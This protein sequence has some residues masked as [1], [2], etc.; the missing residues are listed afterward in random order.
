MAK[1]LVEPQK[2]PASE[3]REDYHVAKHLG[4]GF[5]KRER[6][7]K[8]RTAQEKR[9]TKAAK[10]VQAKK[11][12]RNEYPSKK[13]FNLAMEGWKDAM[14]A[15]VKYAAAESRGTTSLKSGGKAE[16]EQEKKEERRLARSAARKA[17]SAARR[18]REENMTPDERW[19]ARKASRKKAKEMQEAL[20]TTGIG[21]DSS[22][23]I[24][25]IKK[26]KNLM[27][28]QTGKVKKKSSDKIETQKSWQAYPGETWKE[29]NKRRREERTAARLG[30]KRERLSKRAG[31]RG[32]GDEIRPEWQEGDFWPEE[33][34][35]LS[36]GGK[37]YAS[38]TRTANY[39]AG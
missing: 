22:T 9:I 6:F 12:F 4:R 18:A 32:I 3:Y 29:S 15:A 28:A 8:V 30:R 1:E 20:L 21:A 33:S 14:K 36:A 2:K 34:K 10:R 16:D 37:V 25:K 7:E 39:T 31:R 13:A 23:R 35:N 19:E 11:P 27:A 24:R 5:E 26:Q 17:T 38:S